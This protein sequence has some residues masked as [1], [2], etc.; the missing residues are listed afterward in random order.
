MNQKQRKLLH[1]WFGTTR[2]L[3]NK[4]IQETKQKQNFNFQSLRNQLVTKQY[5]IYYCSECYKLKDSL[6][7]KCCGIF[8]IEKKLQNLRIKEWEINT[9][10]EIR[11]HAIKDVIKAYKS[12]FSKKK[13]FDLH[14]RSKKRNIGSLGIQKQ[15]ISFKNNKL[16]MYSTFLKPIILGKKTLKRLKD[17]KYDCRLTFDGLYFNLI[18]PYNKEKQ[19]YKNQN[20][21]VALDPGLRSFQTGYSERETFSIERNKLLKQLKEKLDFL[22]TKRRFKYKRKKKQRKIDFVVDDIHWNTIKYVTKNYNHILLPEFESQEMMGQNKHNNRSFNILKHFKFKQRFKF[23]INEISNVNLYIVNES[24][25][26]KTCS[27]CGILNTEL[28]SNK[29]FNCLNE[30]CNLCIDRDINGA[31]NIFIKHIVL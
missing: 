12:C 28:K 10:K 17:I 3:Y 21:I 2:F 4:T 13:P 7:K 11:A 22:S 14:F 30:D 5:K 29:I 9:P 15:S 18:I 26:S 6:H 31:R 24:F 19:E 8:P 25:T 20:G 1:D 23:Y 27:K 16:Q